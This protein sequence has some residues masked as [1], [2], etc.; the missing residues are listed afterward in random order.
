MRYI[1]AYGMRAHSTHGEEDR[2]EYLEYET[3]DSIDFLVTT[4]FAVR[5]LHSW[6]NTLIL[7]MPRFPHE[8]A[9]PATGHGDDALA[10]ARWHAERASVGALFA[11][12]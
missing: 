12:A 3:K 8:E 6:S 7:G 5:S 1:I 9:P 10:P 2:P 11:L 4:P